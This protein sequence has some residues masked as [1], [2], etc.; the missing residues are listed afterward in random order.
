MAAAASLHGMNSKDFLHPPL[1]TNTMIPCPYIQTSVVGGSDA[2]RRSPLG[3]YGGHT[4]NNRAR[5]K[6]LDGT[7]SDDQLLYLPMKMIRTVVQSPLHL[8]VVGG[9]QMPSH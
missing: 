1:P 4:N 2:Q 5:Y 3:A 8:V 9:Y 6:S 7:L